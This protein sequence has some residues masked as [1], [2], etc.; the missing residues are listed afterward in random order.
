ME[1]EEL[2]YKLN[3]IYDEV[4]AIRMQ[5]EEQEERE[6]RNEAK[7]KKEE[8]EWTLRELEQMDSHRFHYRDELRESFNINFGDK[9]KK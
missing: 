1:K 2:N 7:M 5:L 8:A 6:K 9:E 4:L 3:K